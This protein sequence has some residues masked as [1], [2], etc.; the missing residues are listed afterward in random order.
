MAT[1]IGA[2]PKLIQWRHTDRD[3]NGAIRTALAV[4]PTEGTDPRVAY[5]RKADGSPLSTS[6]RIRIIRSLSI[7]T[8]ITIEDARSQGLAPVGE[9]DTA[10]KLGGEVRGSSFASPGHVYAAS[11]LGR[12]LLLFADPGRH[13]IYNATTHEGEPP[14]LDQSGPEQAIGADKQGETGALPALAVGALLVAAVAGLTFAAC[15]CGQAAAEVIDRKLTADAL[16]ARM[17]Q[18][19][20][21]AIE[22]VT[23][24]TAR[25]RAE[26]RTIP[27]SAE[28]KQVLEALLGTQHAVAKQTGSPL[29]NPFAGATRSMERVADKAG[30]GIGLGAAAAAVVAGVY[31]ATR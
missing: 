6:D 11:T 24:H 21:K 17:V 1:M 25:E 8:L 31:L 10:L 5:Q 30:L 20:A 12:T 2:P 3:L 29:P 27:Y 14:V 22:L 4:R 13:V 16:T 18:T 23:A 26:K 7:A 28:E 9:M 19:Q 15:Y